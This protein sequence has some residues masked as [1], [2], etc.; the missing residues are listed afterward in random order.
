MGL[1]PRTLTAAALVP[2]TKRPRFEGALAAAETPLSV[3]RCRADSGGSRALPSRLESTNPTSRAT[4]TAAPGSHRRPALSGAEAA[5]LPGGAHTAAEVA[6]RDGGRAVLIAG[7]GVLVGDLLCD[8]AALSDNWGFTRW[9]FFDH[10]PIE[11]K[12]LSLRTFGT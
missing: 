11:G 2:P 1:L 12:A 4:E 7:C 9:D 6:G 8:A 5:D 3:S 10:G